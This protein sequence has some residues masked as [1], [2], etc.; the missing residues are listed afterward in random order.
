MKFRLCSL[1]MI[2]CLFVAPLHASPEPGTLDYKVDQAKRS[3][4]DFVAVDVFAGPVDLS[5]SL[6]KDR[7]SPHRAATEV[8][9]GATIAPIQQDALKSLAAAAPQSIT[10]ELPYLAE[11]SGSLVLE[12]LKV[13]IFSDDFSVVTAVPERDTDYDLGVH[14]QGVVRGTEGSLVAV[15]FYRNEVMGLVAGK[16]LGTI[17]IGRLDSNNKNGDHIVYDRADLKG[18]DGLSCSTGES[19]DKPFKAE[20]PTRAD[21]AEAVTPGFLERPQRPA[22]KAAGD[23]VRL[24]YETDYNIYQNKGSTSGVTSYVTGI[25]NQVAAI[26]SGESINTGLSQVFVWN[27]SGDPYTG[28]NAD[29]LLNQFQ[30]YRQGVNGDLGQ[31]LKLSSG[32]SGKAAGFAGICAGNPDN[33]LSVSFIT[34]SYSTVPTYSDTVFVVAHEFGHTFGSRH[35]HACVWNGNGTAIDSCAGYTEGSCSMPGFPSGGGTIMSYCSLTSAGVNFNNGFGSQPGNVIRGDVAAGSCLS[36]SCGGGGGG[37]GGGGSCHSGSPGSANYC[38]ASC[39]CDD[40]EGDC[41]SNSEC[42]NGTTC[43]NNVGPNYG[44]ASWVDV[45]EAPS[46]PNSCVGNCGGQAPGGCYCDSQ[47]SFYGDCCSDKVSVCG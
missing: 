18:L 3:G 25:H 30:S 32:V 19:A 37:G 5:K 23:C 35:T 24:Y 16:D 7:F 28:T 42:T 20:P 11:G 13:N 17:V 34:S 45:C 41:D 9:S 39:P 44:W 21:F 26:Y 1:L 31:L 2:L 27:T 4:S 46:N 12:L 38:S 8:L 33:S 29:T 10:M 22:T 14:Y 40:G 6:T 15:S 36:A 43:V 47:C